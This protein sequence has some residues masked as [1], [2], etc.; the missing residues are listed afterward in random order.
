MKDEIKQ[1]EEITWYLKLVCWVLIV[2][3]C[4]GLVYLLKSI[5]DYV[6]WQQ[7][8][9]RRIDNLERIYSSYPT[10]RLQ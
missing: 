1:E 9:E 7:G 2:L 6:T 3:A 8:L 10:I 4:F 5:A